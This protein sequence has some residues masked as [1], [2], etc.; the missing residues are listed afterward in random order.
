MRIMIKTSKDKQHGP[1]WLIIMTKMEKSILFILTVSLISK[2]TKGQGSD[3]WDEDYDKDK[4]CASE[5]LI[6]TLSGK[7]NTEPLSHQ[8]QCVT[9][10]MEDPSQ[11]IE[12]CK[13]TLTQK[14]LRPCMANTNNITKT[15][16]LLYCH[17]R[18]TTTCCI[19]N[20][21]CNGYKETNENLKYAAASYMTDKVLYLEKEVNKRGF[22]NCYPISGL[23]AKKC[24][25]EC[26]SL[27]QSSPLLD[28]CK[29]KGGLLKCCVRRD[30]V[31]C[32]ECR[33]CCTLPFCSYKGEHGE[34][35]VEGENILIANKIEDQE[36]GTLAVYELR[37]TNSFYKGY[38]N[39]C[40]KPD[41]NKPAEK[42][43]HYDPDEFY[44]A[45][46]KEE[47]EQAKTWEFD[48][49][50]FNFEDPDVMKKFADKKDTDIWKKTYG[51][52]YVHID[53]RA[54]NCTNI[55]LYPETIQACLKMELKSSFAKKCRKDKGFFKC[56]H[57]V[58][59]LSVFEDARQYLIEQS[60][61]EK[62]VD[63]EIHPNVVAAVVTYS[64]TVRDEFTGEFITRYNS[65]E[66][67]PIGGSIINKTRL[68]FRNMLCLS[69]NL[70]LKKLGYYGTDLY[71]YNT[72]EE[73]CQAE[74]K[75]QLSDIRVKGDPEGVIES[76]DSC[77]K[78]KSVIRTCPTEVL[79]AINSS[80]VI[81]MN[82]QVL[83]FK[84]KMERK[85]KGSRKMDK[86]KKRKKKKKEKL[87]KAKKSKKRKKKKRNSRNSNESNSRN[88]YK[89]R[90][91]KKKKK[92]RKG[93]S[94]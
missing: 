71:N 68:G 89:M 80:D 81:E 33:Y 35:I 12:D 66:K 93:S 82:N 92:T 64:C 65:P 38:D 8:K 34:I 1:P 40:L 32:D 57:T 54:C 45:I 51:F 62:Q 30:K 79:K 49:N 84:K 59:T 43:D 13:R 6:M 7:S 9:N 94:S 27:L 11:A 70:C 48:K 31:F 53:H 91:N 76:V 88:R 47:L 73:F 14:V 39:R 74:N 46:N 4:N 36:I 86:K 67:N 77:M 42:W 87:N 17:S 28:H 18:A 55:K 16:E 75:I 58:L 52:D 85:N 83:E 61:I 72:R 37:A 29:K 25:E 10:T 44:E 69:M 23:D 24:A 26:K 63:D 56:C 5:D 20:F 15:G 50:F 3:Y 90:R 60:H 41:D 21:T 2:L 22:H 78:R 19:H